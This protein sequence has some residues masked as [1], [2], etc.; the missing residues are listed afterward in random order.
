MV[1][2]HLSL[3]EVWKLLQSKWGGKF[4]VVHVPLQ[5]ALGASLAEDILSPINVPHYPASAVDGYAVLSI[6]TSMATAAT[7]A[8]LDEGQFQWV[9]TGSFVPPQFDAVVMVEDTSI[10][11]G[12]LYVYESELP[13]ANLRP[14]GEDV[15]KGQIVAQDRK[16][17][18]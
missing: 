11:E 14:I 7:P 3:Y 13:G 8:I 10:K 15:I 2:E 1:K 12:K 9:N 5:Q 18:V 17:V 16:S 4:S 6:S